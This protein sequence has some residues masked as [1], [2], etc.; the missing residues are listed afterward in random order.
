VVVVV[1]VLVADVVAFCGFFFRVLE[2][3][4]LFGQLPVFDI[5]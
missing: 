5:S 4:L 2:G 3:L 1:A